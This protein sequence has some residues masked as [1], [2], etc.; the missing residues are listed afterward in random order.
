MGLDTVE[1]A[2]E[3]EDAFSIT[4]P[5]EEASRIETVGDVF[6]YIVEKTNVP[7][8]ST[9]CLSAIVFYSLRDA[10]MKLGVPNTG[11]R[12]RLRP[13]DLTAEI[14]PDSN[15]RR[16]WS[17]L[18][19]L[20][21]LTLPPLQRPG[22]LVAACSMVVIAF[23]ALFGF[24]AYQSTGSELGGIVAA[25]ITGVE[26]GLIVAWLTR[27]FAVYPDSNCTTLR[28]LSESAMGMNLKTLSER[29][30]TANKS[31]LWIALRSIIVK[32][33]GV[34]PDEVKPTASFVRDLGCD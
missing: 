14:L 29:Y 7:T 19:S 26:L 25:I 15:Q 28:G 12:K 20:S 13:K 24:L 18:Q 16:F 9:I 33:L 10:A 17:Q 2:M 5:H 32:Q 3:I 6:D 23:S 1:L 31:D 4:I 34:S 11:I 30:N 8:N 22:W 27:P 21:K